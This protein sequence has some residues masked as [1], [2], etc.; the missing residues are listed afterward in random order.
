MA[1]TR[2]PGVRLADSASEAYRYPLLIKQLLHTPLATSPDEQIVYRD[3]HRYRYSEFAERL[4][5]LGGALHR[6]GVDPG[7]TVAVMDWDSHRFLECYFA[8][9]MSGA[10]LQTVNTRLAPEQI[11][12]TLEDSGAQ[13]LLFHRDF[14]P[15]VESL[16]PHLLGVRT[17]VILDDEATPDRPAFV[18]AA[19]EEL[20]AE[21]AAGFEFGEFDENAVATTFHTTGTTGRPKAVVFTHRQIV[22]H[23][24]AGIGSLA[25]ATHGQSFRRGGVYMPLTPMFHVHAWGMPYVATLLGVKQVY[26]GRYQPEELLALRAREG[27]TYS[28]CVPTVLRMVLSTAKQL[29]VDLGG[30]TITIGG[31]ALPLG[32][33][34][35]ALDAGID[36][37]AGYGMSETGPVLTVARLDGTE[38]DPEER[39]RRRCLAGRP[40]PLVELRIADESMHIQPRDG[41]STGEVIVRA[42]WLTPGY[43]GDP[44]ASEQLWRGGYLH[45]QDVGAILPTGE[46]RISDR[47]KDVIKSGGEWISSLQLEEIISH[48]P[49]VAEAAV[50]GEADPLW[51]ERPHAHVVPRG[52]TDAERLAESVRA[53]VGAEVERGVLPKYAIP[54]RVT[55]TAALPKTSVGK[56]DKRRL[57][58]GPG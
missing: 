1:L 37:H 5:R 25:S 27:V 45:T 22:L 4:P 58:E 43:A 32:L 46:L 38:S 56:I 50:V 12:F 17:F 19:Y 53:A 14:L 57:R 44:A 7:S 2:T 41:V 3:R 47:L 29:G 23:T 31:S 10:V 9:P 26:P 24:L 28:H 35:E 55:I 11:R 48:V 33:A 39:I 15:L 18:A 42:P 8:I 20:L 16:R 21:P 36:V 13:T 49:D 51:G 30:W 40:I 34:R 54:E 52:R 6:L